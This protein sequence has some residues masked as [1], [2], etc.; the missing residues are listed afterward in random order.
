MAP[1]PS[2]HESDV[3][4]TY[5]TLIAFT[6]CESTTVAI[7]LIGAPWYFTLD[8]T[9]YWLLAPWTLI[10]TEGA[11][12]SCVLIG[13]WH[14][15]RAVTSTAPMSAKRIERPVNTIDLLFGLPSYIFEAAAPATPLPG[16]YRAVH[17]SLVR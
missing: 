6:P 1:L 16:Q 17:S 15:V 5:W 3:A 2:V 13:T 9:S 7:T 12:A 10:V 4:L 8:W 14:A 11:L